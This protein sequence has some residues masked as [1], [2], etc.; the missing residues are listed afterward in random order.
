MPGAGNPDAKAQK[1]GY[2]GG[3]GGA[4]LLYRDSEWHKVKAD[5]TTGSNR[6]SI[7][8]LANKSLPETSEN[9]R[10]LVRYL[11]DLEQREFT[12][13]TKKHNNS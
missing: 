10:D 6:T 5:R 3:K 13:I 12:Y 7:I 8:Q 2:R 4:G 9:A 1:C 11:Q